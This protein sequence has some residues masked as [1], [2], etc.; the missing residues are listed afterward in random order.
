MALAKYADNQTRFVIAHP[1]IVTAAIILF[2]L[3]GSDRLTELL[4]RQH[5]R[6]LDVLLTVLFFFFPVFWS[7]FVVRA[8]RKLQAGQL[9]ISTL[10]E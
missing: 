1:G 2:T 9:P 7:Y 3:I 8:I 10:N 4:E 5:L 6:T